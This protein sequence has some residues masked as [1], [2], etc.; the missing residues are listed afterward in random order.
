MK[1]KRQK[2]KPKKDQKIFKKT[3]VRTKLINNEKVVP[4]GGI[5]L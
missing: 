3:A 2:V 5:R 1:P 4:R